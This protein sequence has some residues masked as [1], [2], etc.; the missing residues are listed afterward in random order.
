MQFEHFYTLLVT[1]S[2]LFFMFTTPLRAVAHSR[3]FSLLTPPFIAHRHHLTKHSEE[4]NGPKKYYHWVTTMSTDQEN[5]LHLARRMLMTPNTPGLTE[6]KKNFKLVTIK[7]LRKKLSHCTRSHIQMHKRLAENYV[8]EFST[9][10]FELARNAITKILHL[11]SDKNSC[12]L[13]CIVIRMRMTMFWL[14][15]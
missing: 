10:S 13:E 15:S 2:G 11:G 14:K 7:A 1:F 8:I 3:H 9:S 6:R 5:V 4:P 12:R